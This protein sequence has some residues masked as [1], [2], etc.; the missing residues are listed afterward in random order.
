MTDFA[1]LNLT[2]HSERQE[3]G[4]CLWHR[5][6]RL[7]RM[8]RENFNFLLFRDLL[9]IDKIPICSKPPTAAAFSKVSEIF[10]VQQWGSTFI[11]A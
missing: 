5:L 10:A 8:F 9:Q 1:R 11:Q 3:R 7:S 2:L 6:Q 4:Y